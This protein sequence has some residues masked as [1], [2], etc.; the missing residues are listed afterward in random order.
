M[1]EDNG[2]ESENDENLEST[3]DQ[4]DDVFSAS[5]DIAQMLNSQNFVASI[6]HQFARSEIRRLNSL[7]QYG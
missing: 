1:R 5:S 7:L 2:F 6:V 3:S 4:S